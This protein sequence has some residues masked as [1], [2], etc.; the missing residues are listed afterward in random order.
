MRGDGAYT[1]PKSG[2]SDKPP[3][4]HSTDRTCSK[5]RRQDGLLLFPISSAHYPSTCHQ[6]SNIINA[7]EGPVGSEI[8]TDLATRPSLIA[9]ESL[10][11]IN[12]AAAAVNSGK[13]VIGRY[14]WSSAGSF[15]RISVACTFQITVHPAI[16]RIG[17]SIG[18]CEAIC[19]HTPF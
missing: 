14:S 8:C 4:A 15:R 10:P 6:Y 9:G 7:E 5:T 11:S 13:P 18:P 12:F 3:S 16:A 19:L 2:Y 17:V 1:Y